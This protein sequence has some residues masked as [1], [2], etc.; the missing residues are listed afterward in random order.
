ML[1]LN[2]K[3]CKKKK[4]NRGCNARGLCMMNSGAD[5]F[6][7]KFPPGASVLQKSLLMSGLFLENYVFWER[8]A[9][10]K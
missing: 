5:N 4:K 6:I 7:V 3:K 2:S 1:H 9:N 8:R 10:Q